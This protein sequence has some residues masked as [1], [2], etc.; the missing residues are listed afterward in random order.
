MGAEFAKEW[1]SSYPNAWA[2]NQRLQA[3]PAVAK[4]REDRQKAVAA[5]K[6]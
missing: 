4:A 3:R 2:W 5:S 6:H 1:E